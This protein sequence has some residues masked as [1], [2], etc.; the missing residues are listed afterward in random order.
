MRHV[1]PKNILLPFTVT[2]RNY[3]V[4]ALHRVVS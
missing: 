4:E 1:T 2:E 3:L